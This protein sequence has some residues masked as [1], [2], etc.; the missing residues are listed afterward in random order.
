MMMMMMMSLHAENAAGLAELARGSTDAQVAK[1]PDAPL[2]RLL[3]AVGWLV[4]CL[5]Q[6]RQAVGVPAET[7][8]ELQQMN[9]Y[10]Q[11][12]MPAAMLGLCMRVDEA[13]VRNMMSPQSV[14]AA[15]MANVMHRI[16]M[17][18]LVQTPH[19]Y[20]CNN[21]GVLASE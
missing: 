20:A 9:S 1:K 15:E 17:P 5:Q 21:P 11:M 19:A 14:G 4:D 16:A 12:A 8:E 13:A 18:V 7:V 2:Q 6:H 10:V 3:P